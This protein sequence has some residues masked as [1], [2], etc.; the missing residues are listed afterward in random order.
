MGEVVINSFVSDGIYTCGTSAPGN[1][2]TTNQWFVDNG[3]PTG[4]LGNDGDFYLDLDT[5]TVYEKIA[6]SWVIKGV[7][8]GAA[9]RDDQFQRQADEIIMAGQPVYLTNTGT[10]KLAKADAD[11]QRKIAGFALSDI[12]IGN[13]G[14]IITDGKL[15]LSDWT[16]VIGSSNL[17]VGVEYFLDV[18]NF[19]MIITAASLPSLNTPG[20]FIIPVGRAIKPDELDI[21]I[22]AHPI[23]L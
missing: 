5:S 2:G 23:R 15:A 7:L 9:E 10:I 20:P 8:A 1:G 6:G 11:P 18:L 16:N 13:A 3:V 22:E 12:A 14:T 19:G 4:A 17:S 21:K